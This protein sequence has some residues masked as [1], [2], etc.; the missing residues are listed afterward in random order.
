[1]YTFIYDGYGNTDTIDVGGSQIVDYEYYPNNGKL[2][3]I[4]YA[5]GFSEEY[6]YDSLDRLSEFRYPS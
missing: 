4:I 6:V 2:K 5:N 1:M 3:K